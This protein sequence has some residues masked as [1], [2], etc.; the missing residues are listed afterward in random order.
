MHIGYYFDELEA[1]HAYNNA[2]KKLHG[3]F[4]FLNN[5]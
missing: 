4:A 5:V 3:S 1:A 2:A